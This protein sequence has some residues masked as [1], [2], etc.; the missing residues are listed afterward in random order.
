[1]WLEYLR[2]AVAVL[3]AH[4][5]RSL[6]TVVSITIGAF[7]IV[8]MTSLAD[9]GLKTLFV[10]IEEL[11]GSR[12]LSVWR[13][14]PDAMEARQLSYT[15]GLTRQD[16]AALRDIPHLRDI[17]QLVTLRNK[18]LQT[19]SGAQLGGDVIAADGRFFSF[20]H[21]RVGQG[22]LFDAHDLAEHARVCVIGDVL[23]DKLFGQGEQVI[24]RSVSALGARCKIIGRL[25]K[26]D[27]WGIRFGWQWDE[28]LAI[29]LETLTDFMQ[30]DLDS[31][32]QLF[33]QTDDP[34]HNDVVKRIMNA[35]LMERHHDVDDF[36]IFDLEKRL[37]GFFQLFLIM[38]VIVALISAITMIVG[39][40]GIMNI[41][42]VSVAERVREIGIR[43]ALG[44][45]PKDIGR[46]FLVEAALL[47]LAG[48]LIGI[49]TGMGAAV[50][51]S[52]L[53]AHFK[54][55]WVTS[56]SQP[57]VIASLTV[58]VLVGAVFGYFPARRAGRMDPVQAIRT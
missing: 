28:L 3:R 41:M 10:G 15:R 30:R 42:L 56:I 11:G 5:A 25:A 54:P 53:I 43:K 1:V 26:V 37:Q 58:A 33:L 51:G 20:F 45:S 44:A 48:G 12:L 16:V 46:Q 14:A 32:R 55:S 4:K 35:R 47:S 50:A 36:A 57:A 38:K 29:P 2:I 19:D 7:S 23:A 21:Y 17:T 9:S 13:K 24:G 18:V 49:L 8:L 27:R 34:S 6:L 22:R 39:G 31:G 52:R 40:V